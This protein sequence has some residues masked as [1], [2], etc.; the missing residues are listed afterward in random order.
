M[1]VACQRT[2]K[3]SRSTVM[4]YHTLMAITDNRKRMALLSLLT[5]ATLC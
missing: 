2:I 1:P 5:F 4:L 3:D